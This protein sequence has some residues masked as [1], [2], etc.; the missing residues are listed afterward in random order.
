MS[1]C[2]KAMKTIY[3]S[4]QIRRNLVVQDIETGTQTKND[5]YKI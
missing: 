4:A 1:F 5:I 3:F 2:G